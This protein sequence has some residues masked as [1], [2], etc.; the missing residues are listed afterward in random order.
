MAA[1]ATRGSKLL[2]QILIGAAGSAVVLMIDLFVIGWS[3]DNGTI[4]ILVT[5]VVFSVAFLAA[6]LLLV[7]EQPDSGNGRDVL[8]Q[9][10]VSGTM[11]VDADEIAANGASS[12]LSSNKVGGDMTVKADKISS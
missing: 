8:S 7:H 6:K 2:R 3:H 10:E 12:A 4:R 1:G 9:N 11:S 5:A